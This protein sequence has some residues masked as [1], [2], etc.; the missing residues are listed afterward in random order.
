MH[1]YLVGLWEATVL[2]GNSKLYHERAIF[3]THALFCM[4]I[5]PLTYTLHSLIKRSVNT[6]KLTLS[7]S[8]QRNDFVDIR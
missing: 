7:F 3:L 1:S 5:L 4:I 8:L 6:V 2:F